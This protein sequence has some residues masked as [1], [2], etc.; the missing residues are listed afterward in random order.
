MLKNVCLKLFSS[1]ALAHWVFAYKFEKL[2]YFIQA[3][4]AKCNIVITSHV[5]NTA[6]I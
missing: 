3:S 4:N 6:C 2:K 5:E 1:F